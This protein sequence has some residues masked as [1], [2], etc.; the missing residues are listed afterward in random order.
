MPTPSV[1]ELSEKR[2]VQ[3]EPAS[4]APSGT[5]PVTC[6]PRSRV[7]ALS[8]A[9]NTRELHVIAECVG[10]ICPGRQAMRGNHT[11]IAM[12]VPVAEHFQMCLH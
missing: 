12:R 5:A 10:D 6:R 4:P 2:L 8:S 7:V 3:S 11:E 1:F 9:W